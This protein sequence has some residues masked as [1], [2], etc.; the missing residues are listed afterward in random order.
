MP[1]HEAK[2]ALSVNAERQSLSAAQI[3]MIQEVPMR[4]AVT[5]AALIALSPVAAL[6][7]DAEAGAGAFQSQCSTCHMVV[8]EAGETLAGRNSRTGP[9]LY[10][11]VGRQAG[12]VDGF[13]YGPSLVEAGTGGLVWDDETLLA[14]LQ[15]PQGFL[16][17]TLGNNR[18]RSQMSFQVRNAETAADIV[19]FL[20]TFS[21]VVE[22]EPAEE[23][24]GEAEEG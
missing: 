13:R 1:L 7:G 4:L 19:A 9:N 2:Y 24:E 18:A 17:E 14:Y 6:A 22:E 8:N 10:Q 11:I 23:A 16:R 5:T 21:P 15:N 20:A 12:T 3:C